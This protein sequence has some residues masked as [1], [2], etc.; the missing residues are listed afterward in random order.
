MRKH[1]DRIDTALKL[2]FTL[3]IGTVP[4]A[5][6]PYTSE[7]FEFNKM[8]LVYIY[9]LI[10]FF[11]WGT[12]AIIQR[13]IEIRRT[14]FDIPLLLFFASQLIATVISMDPHTSFWDI[15]LDL[16]EVFFQHFPTFLFTMLL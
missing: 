11:L 5:M 15:I 7:L 13:K 9:A 10:I 2:T 6:H 4:L 14:P 8:W 16:M 12:K 3:L 1:I